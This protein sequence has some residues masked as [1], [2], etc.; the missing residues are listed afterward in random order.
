MDNIY[1]VY[2]WVRLDNNEPF[3]VGKG[4]NNRWRTKS[5][6]NNHFLNIV[7]SIPCAVILLHENLTSD[8]ACDLECYYIEHYKY[9]IGYDL[10]NITDGGEG[11]SGFKPNEDKLKKMRTIYH[12]FD[13]EDN[14]DE[15]LKMYNDMVPLNKI[16]KV[17]GVSKV[18]I[19]KML[20]RHGI[21][22]RTQGETKKISQ[23]DKIRTDS[24]CIKIIKNNIYYYFPTIT[25]ASVW[26][27]ENKYSKSEKG[28]KKIIYNNIKKN[29][30]YKDIEIYNISQDEFL[31]PHH[32]A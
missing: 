29:N 15:I 2:E 17:F 7:N 19:V 32:G 12:G 24:T 30:K 27:F 11:V 13:I 21:T 16:G 5:S 6:R 31:A 8:E 4:K 18:V 10:V 26:M 20:K 1:Y 28:G 23:I 9:A 14:Y 3:Y 25:R 22:I